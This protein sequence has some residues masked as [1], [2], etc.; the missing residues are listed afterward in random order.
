M[1]Q[2]TVFNYYPGFTRWLERNNV[3]AAVIAS[4]RKTR[5][6]LI[7]EEEFLSLVLRVLLEAPYTENATLMLVLCKDNKGRV[8]LLNKYETKPF[9]KVRRF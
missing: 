9:F 3:P 8:F 7:K 4:Y 5:S 1:R 2:P 6:D